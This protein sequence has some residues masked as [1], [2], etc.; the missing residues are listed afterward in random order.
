M[1][2]TQQ[3]EI[4]EFLGFFRRE[5]PGFVQQAS[6]ERGFSTEEALSLSKEVF[7]VAVTRLVTAYKS[8]QLNSDDPSIALNLTGPIELGDEPQEQVVDG[9]L[10]ASAAPEVTR[11]DCETELNPDILVIPPTTMSYDPFNTPYKQVPNTFLQPRQQTSQISDLNW[12]PLI[13]QA[14]QQ[15][16]LGFETFD[17]SK[18]VF[19]Q[20]LIDTRD[21]RDGGRW[22][23]MNSSTLTYEPE[24]DDP[25]TLYE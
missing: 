12:V 22:F 25:L 20:I 14:D 1:D 13:P 17:F 9:V 23:P 8:G 15:Q 7:D 16:L 10:S 4:N 2:E 6:I 5:A 19:D 11:A 18:N 24:W 3:E 21:R